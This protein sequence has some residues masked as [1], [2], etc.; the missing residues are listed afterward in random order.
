MMKNMGLAHS[1]WHVGYKM[2]WRG[3]LGRINQ[4]GGPDGDR[5]VQAD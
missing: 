2:A 4:S 1:A 3:S 5:A